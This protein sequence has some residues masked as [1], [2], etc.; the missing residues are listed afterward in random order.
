V[1]RLNGKYGGKKFWDKCLVILLNP[2]RKIERLIKN[3]NEVTCRKYVSAIHCLFIFYD[4][5]TCLLKCYLF[6][7]WSSVIGTKVN[8]LPQMAVTSKKIS[9]SD[10]AGL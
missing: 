9:V 3:K 7:L 10:Q 4:N 6:T 2:T 8:Q 1:V 5:Q